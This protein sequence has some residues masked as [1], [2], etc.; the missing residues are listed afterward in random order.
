MN[1]KTK[2]SPKTIFEEKFADLF[3]PNFGN[4][5]LILRENT[6]VLTLDYLEKSNGD[7]W[8]SLLKQVF[9]FFPGTLLLFMT[10]GF[11]FDAYFSGIIDFMFV[12]GGLPWILMYSFMMIFGIGDI[13][14]PKHLA[15]PLSVVSVSLLIFLISTFLPDSL[16]NKF[17]YEYSI[18]LFPIA[19]ILPNFVKNVIEESEKAK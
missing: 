16:H 13:K 1:L 17:L 15:I 8:I 2:T 3:T 12:I 10:S 6:G 18:Y 14:N 19:L 7:M 11:I 5:E 9:L 4:E